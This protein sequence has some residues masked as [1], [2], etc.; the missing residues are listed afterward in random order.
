MAIVKLYRAP[1]IFGY[2]VKMRFEFDGLERCRLGPQESAFILLEDRPY[3]FSSCLTNGKKPHSEI[4]DFSKNK[5][6]IVSVKPK[7]QK[8]KVN[9]ISFNPSDTEFY[10]TVTVFNTLFVDETHKKWSLYSELFK[11][12]PRIFDYTDLVDFELVKDGH[13]ITTGTT[14]FN[15][16]YK[17]NF[18]TRGGKIKGG[19]LSS[20]RSDFFCRKLELM[21]TV[22]DMYDPVIKLD[23]LGAPADTGTVHGEVN[24]DLAYEIAYQLMGRL[25]LII[26]SETEKEVNPSTESKAQE[27]MK[28]KQLL[29]SGAITQAEF[30]TLK[31][32][33]LSV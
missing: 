6:C 11:H 26:N 19:A 21:I 8:N 2:G 7:Y 4:I 33:L 14:S 17:E 13:T 16:K 5:I 30:E 32:H 31:K 1:S 24:Y 29:D 18:F 25:N 15:G 23:L 22:K 10:P 12:N 27:L 20:S 9:V 3:V 28:Y